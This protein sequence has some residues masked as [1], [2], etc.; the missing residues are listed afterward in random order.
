MQVNQ[1][2]EKNKSTIHAV[3]FLGLSPNKNSDTVRDLVEIAKG[4]NIPHEIPEC[5][6][7]NDLLSN[8]AKSIYDHGVK[9]G[10]IIINNKIESKSVKIEESEDITKE[11]DTNINNNEDI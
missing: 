5:T 7:C 10:V 2:I 1:L 6:S 4:L 8:M 11:S 9:T 3:A